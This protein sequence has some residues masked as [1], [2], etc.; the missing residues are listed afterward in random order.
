MTRYTEADIQ[1]ALADIQNGVPKS[2]AAMW[3]GI[4]CTTLRGRICGS[5]HHKVAYSSMQRLSLEQEEHLAHWIFGQEA[6]NY[7]L[8]HAQV[9]AIATGPQTGWRFSTFRKEMDNT[10]PEPS[11]QA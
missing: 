11:S 2:T 7:T 1:N 10:L 4:P 6:L 3:H 5:Q 9:R 8:T